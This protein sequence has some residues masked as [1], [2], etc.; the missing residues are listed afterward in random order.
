[1]TR[2]S[3]QRAEPLP[4][5]NVITHFSSDAEE[6]C[7]GWW[8]GDHRLA[9]PSF[10]SYGYPAP[11][12]I[13]TVRLQPHEAAWNPDAGEFLFAYDAAIAAPDPRRAISE[14]LATSYDGIAR[15]MGWRN[16]LTEVTA[17]GQRST[18]HAQG[19]ST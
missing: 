12:D 2:Y 7:S 4:G 8:P 9:A 5:D 13:D 15:L 14:F 18:D 19:R 16:D 3:G 11:P 17:P 6:V 1:M 10:F